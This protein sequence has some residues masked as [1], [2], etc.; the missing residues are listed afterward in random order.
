MAERGRPAVRLRFSEDL[1]PRYR[2]DLR[3]QLRPVRVFLLASIAAG[4]GLAPFQ[5]VSVFRTPPELQGILLEFLA[6]TITPLAL[7][8]AALTYFRAQQILTQAFQSATVVCT[9]AG[10]LALRYFA[11]TTSFEY[12]AGMLGTAAIAV[13]VFGGFGWFRLLPALLVFFVA[14]IAQEFVLA[15]AGGTPV[16]STHLLLYSLII[17]ALGSYTNEVLRRRNWLSHSIAAR[18]AR[19][20]VLTGLSN[21]ADFER[22][23]EVSFSSGRRERKGIA[24]MVL[25][26]DDFKRINDRYGHAAGDRALRAIGEALAKSAARRPLDICA[27]S[28]GE[29]FVVVW[30]DVSAAAVPMLAEQV[31]D[32]IRAISLPVEKSAEP[33][34]L[35]ASAGACWTVPDDSTLAENLLHE[36]DRLM[37]GAKT[38]GRNR[39]YFAEYGRPP[40]P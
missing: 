32:A 22:R 20:D 2:A 24:V 31:L 17:S 40:S 1:E 13:A 8:A 37:Y 25:D 12:P 26:L 27:R 30:H 10:V 29:E 21:R 19:I 7:V 23:F 14:G 16:L 33:L 38:A 4:F 11:L 3:R 35:T 6:E 18:L 34:S 9:F 15:P 36:A 39:A 28:G 5:E